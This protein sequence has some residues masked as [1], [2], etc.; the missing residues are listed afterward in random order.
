MKFAS[1]TPLPV[2]RSLA[3]LGQA[4]S[5]A[6]RR[7]DL[8]QDELAQRIGASA[9]TVRRME[10]G[11][12]GPTRTQMDVF[13]GQAKKPLG[14]LIFVKDGPRQFSQFSYS[15]AQLVPAFERGLNGSR[16]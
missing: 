15:E 2:E 6:R 5:L 9:H 13:W 1:P 16:A 12:P 14:R 7:R 8:T 10:A 11:H 3:R 4:I